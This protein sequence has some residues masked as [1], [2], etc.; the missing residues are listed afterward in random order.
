MQIKKQIKITY[1]CDLNTDNIED[2]LA[3]ERNNVIGIT[4]ELRH[5][6]I[7]AY[8]TGLIKDYEV[9]SVEDI[10]EK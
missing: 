2:I 1:L 6:G 3:D 10:E 8:H 9:E 7:K 5:Q 4:N